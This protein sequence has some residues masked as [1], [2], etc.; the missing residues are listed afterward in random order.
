MKSDEQCN[1][2]RALAD[3]TQS[4]R[5]LPTCS[6]VCVFVR[7]FA[8]RVEE[9][10]GGEDP[11]DSAKV[12]TCQRDQ[13]NL[14]TLWVFFSPEFRFLPGRRRLLERDWP[15]RQRGLRPPR[16]RPH[17]TPLSLPLAR[18]RPRADTC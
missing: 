14:Q 16:H 2:K 7:E 15:L 10:G 13:K 6:Q 4:L 17:L 1:I 12:F 11:V 3:E 5:S 9:G 18:P 8:W